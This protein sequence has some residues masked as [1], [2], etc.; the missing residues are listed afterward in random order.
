MHIAMYRYPSLT[1]R[2]Y[3]DYALSLR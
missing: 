1:Q 3:C 2:W